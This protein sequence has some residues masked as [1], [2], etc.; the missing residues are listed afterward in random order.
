M[1]KNVFV[2]LVLLLILPVCTYSHGGPSTGKMVL[3]IG[4]LV[5]LIVLLIALLIGSISMLV[6]ANE[7]KP[8]EVTSKRI[9]V[10]LIPPGLLGVSG[11]ALSLMTPSFWSWAGIPVALILSSATI[12]YKQ[13]R[14]I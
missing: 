7:L 12:F 4:I 13:F 9:C 8:E 2:S 3:I 1:N 11:L 10:L 6:K 5:F 14:H